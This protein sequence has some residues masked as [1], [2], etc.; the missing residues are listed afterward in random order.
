MKNVI[1]PILLLFITPITLAQPSFC[2]SLEFKF[3]EKNKE[4][5][6][7]SLVKRYQLLDDRDSNIIA[8]EGLGIRKK[9]ES[10]NL[11]FTA[12]VVYNDLIRKFVCNKDTMT[13]YFK[14]YG[15]RGRF[16]YKID[17]LYFKKGKYFIVDNHISKIDFKKT[18]LLY[19]EAF[20]NEKVF[21]EF[22]GY[23]LFYKSYGRN[24]D[25]PNHIALY[26]TK[27]KGAKPLG[28]VSDEGFIADDVVL[29]K[30]KKSYFIYIH[31][32]HTSGNADGKLY[33]LNTET[34]KM[35]EVRF[36]KDTLNI[37]ANLSPWKGF[38]LYWDGKHFTSGTL[39]RSESDGKNYQEITEYA[40][41]K[42]SKDQ[43]VLKP[44]LTDISEM[45]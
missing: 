28:N 30:L 43:Y 20:Q 44:F 2:M 23:E 38:G 17:R 16:Q 12:S 41:K 24:E 35:T 5:E 9:S 39:L 36:K 27:K 8:S 26:A 4:V 37:P 11:W 19:R 32:N 42:V 18:G 15:V 13:L 14:N 3:Y 34:L 40:L 29:L 22:N 21:G 6:L 1:L 31:F 33:H 10:K 45:E 7:S 25:D